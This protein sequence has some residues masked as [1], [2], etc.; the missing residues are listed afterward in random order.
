MTSTVEK[1]KEQDVFVFTGPCEDCGKP[2]TEN[3]DLTGRRGAFT[4]ILR[5]RL[6]QQQ[7]SGYV[8]WMMCD[9]CEEKEQR[10]D[11]AKLEAVQLRHRYEDAGVPLR[12]RETE[13]KD[14]EKDDGRVAAIK[15]TWAWATEAAPLPGLYLYGE[16]GR[17][18]THLAGVAATEMVRAGRKVRWI[19]CAR[20][21][22]NLRGGFDSQSY[23]E[24]MKQLE[25]GE[26]GEILIMDDI[27]KMPTTDHQ[28]QPIY[29]AINE[30]VNLDA[31]MIIT[32]NRDLD[33]LARE[34]G[35]KFGEA[36]ASRII[37]QSVD[38]EVR[39][40]DRRLD[41]VE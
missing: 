35:D 14:L 41:P 12:F 13:W 39:G 33:D 2:V 18:K 8:G 5:E 4:A 40:R 27:D 30:W 25:A 34:F 7:E 20:L 38:V 31:P 21:M 36:I 15:A 37:G 26:A 28:L 23:K 9:D 16:F 32:A 3:Y 24:G 10:R 6:I 1:N 22:T 11:L 17:G 29:T 19:D